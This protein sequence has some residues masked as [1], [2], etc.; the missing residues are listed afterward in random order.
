MV[1]TPVAAGNS[2]TSVISWKKGH[3]AVSGKTTQEL[4]EAFVSTL[5]KVRPSFCNALSVRLLSQIRQT[6][7]FDGIHLFSLSETTFRVSSSFKMMASAKFRI[8]ILRRQLSL[9]IDP[10]AASSLMPR[11]RC[12]SPLARSTN[13]RVSN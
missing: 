4:L 9:C 3:D 1:S 13:L 11:F 5:K 6:Q 12:R 2:L 7:I 10:Y 8:E